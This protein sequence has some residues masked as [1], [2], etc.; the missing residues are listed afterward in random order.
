MPD[1]RGRFVWYENLTNDVDAAIAFYR[2]VIGW[3]TQSWTGH[4]RAVSHVR[5]W[6]RR[7]SRA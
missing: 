2:A 4:G 5:Q 6:R 1:I 3:N 7:R